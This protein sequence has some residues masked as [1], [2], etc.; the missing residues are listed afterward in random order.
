MTEPKTDAIPKLDHML[1]GFVVAFDAETGDVLRVLETSVETVDGKPTH[2]A[3]ITPAECEKVR[4]EA[5]RN[6]PRRR[7]DVI[8]APPD[9][10]QPEGELVRYHVDPMTRKLRVEPE[11]DPRFNA[12]LLS[13]FP[14]RDR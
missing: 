14:I 12:R 2:A 4:A 11:C 7:V 9:M 5:A 10:E 3:E 1:T 6:S 8:T 13:S